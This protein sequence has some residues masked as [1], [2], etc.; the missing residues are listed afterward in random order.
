MGKGTRG[1]HGHTEPFSEQLFFLLGKG[2]GDGH[3][4]TEP[5][6][7]TLSFPSG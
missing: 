1:D 5:S 7:E 4:H 3:D 6:F 2:R